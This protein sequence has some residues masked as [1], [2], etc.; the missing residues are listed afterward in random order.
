MIWL[1]PL[2]CSAQ[3]FERGE[4]VVI[5]QAVHEDLY[6]VGGN[7]TINA[8]IHGDLVVAGGKVII[9]DSVSNDII[10]AGGEITMNGA[11]G[12]DIRCAGG[13]LYVNQNVTGDVLVTGGEVHIAR[14]A[15]I[16]G[17]LMAG[18]GEVTVDG[19]VSG[20]VKAGAGKLALNGSIGKSLDSRGQKISVN[21]P[22]GGEAILAANDLVI[23]QNASFGNKV[24]YW[25]DDAVDFGQ[26]VKSGQ[27]VMDESL[28]IDGG[29]WKY[30][31]FAS[32]LALLWYL[33][34][35]FVFIVLIQFLF[36]RYISRAVASFSAEGTARSVGY[37]FL[38]FVLIPCVIFFALLT[39]IGIPLA[40][41]LIVLYIALIL[42]A[43]VIT[44]VV[45]ANWINRRYYQ[46]QGTWRQVWS[47]L[48][49]FVIIKII[50]LIPVAGWLLMLAT[51][52]LAFGILIQYYRSRRSKARL[53]IPQY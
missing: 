10:I 7:I 46:S 41:L 24:R 40:L 27:P 38:F 9:N 6:V 47:A 13:K 1:I 42:L 22:V 31:G 28:K 25:S 29:S 18:G 37:G 4:D 32:L 53:D 44:S 3:R 30:M 17:S 16:S 23:G 2:W 12:D 39:L 48:A 52:F 26:S 21:G 14:K 50:S 43:S 33:G 11:V 35:A 15:L 51:V 34:A 49:I 20:F 19:K 5:S 36:G 45:L 8:P